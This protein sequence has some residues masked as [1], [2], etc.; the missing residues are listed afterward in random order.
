MQ[1]QAAMQ[2][3]A[4]MQQQAATQQGPAMQQQAAMQ[5]PCSSNAAE[6][7]AHRWLKWQPSSSSIGPMRASRCSITISSWASVCGGV[8][9][10]VGVIEIRIQT[11]QWR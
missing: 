4:A 3:Q 2:P 7:A 11:G 6:T 5:Q 9:E 1:Q 8:F 10:Y